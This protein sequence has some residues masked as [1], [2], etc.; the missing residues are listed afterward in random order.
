M[1]DLITLLCLWGPRD[2]EGWNEYV[3]INERECDTTTVPFLN[4]D[5][6]SL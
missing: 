2:L 3:Q 1:Q 4:L 5:E 6:M